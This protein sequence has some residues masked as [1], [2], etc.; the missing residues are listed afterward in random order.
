MCSSID[1]NLWS[2][3]AILGAQK[4]DRH[5]AVNICSSSRRAISA[6][7]LLQLLLIVVHI[8]VRSHS[9]LS[10]FH[11]VHCNHLLETAAAPPLLTELK[12]HHL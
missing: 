8:C 2:V 7:L 9:S 11:I 3:H 6:Q 12:L 10:I 5:L 4:L 1:S